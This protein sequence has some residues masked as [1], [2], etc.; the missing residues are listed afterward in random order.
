IEDN[1]KLRELRA[2]EKEEIKNI[3]FELSKLLSGRLKELEESFKALIEIDKRYAISMISIKL[4]G[5]FPEFENYIDLK[6]AKHPLLILSQK[7]VV[8]IDVR[9][10]NGLV[11]TGPN[12][13]GKTVCLKTVGLLSIMAQAGFLIPVKEGSTL[14]IF[15]KWMVDIGDEQSIEQNL[16]TFSAHIKKISEILKEANE[17]SLVLL[18]ELG[19]GTDPIEGSTLAVGILKYLKDRKAKVIATTHFTPVKLFAYKDDYYDVAS[20]MFD[21]KTLKPLY[22]LAYGIIGRSYALLIAKRFG[23]PQEVIDTARSLLTSEDR[24]AE[25]II[26]ALEKEYQKLSEER[27][28]V[29][30]IKET[31]KKKEEELQEKEKFLRQK[32]AKEIEKFIEELKEKSDEILKKEASKA[33][34]EIKQIVITAR[35]RAEALKEIP[36]K[37][38][39]EIK[40]G[41]TVK[42]LKSGRK[43]KV[44]EIDKNKNLAKVLIGNLKVDVKLSQLELVEEIVKEEDIVKVNVKKPQKFFP[45]LKLLGLRGEEALRKVEE[46]LDNANLV[47]IKR[48]K[49]VHGYGTGILKRLVREYLKESPYVKSFRPGSIEEGGDGV[50]IVELV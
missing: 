13:G 47:G 5:T 31:L 16:S 30:K 21:E 46:F 29:E 33:K 49:I 24:L 27:K 34:Q 39:K 36:K 17:N 43:G 22:K 14:R 1:N 45:E 41:D 8:P 10:K 12:T 28:E 37:K 9:V 35:N 50:T 11:I 3:L 23:I 19:A 7:E 6:E 38:E 25:D 26:A 32:Y 4:N 20:V 48:V 44:L 40:C 15:K 42:I 2:E 18:D